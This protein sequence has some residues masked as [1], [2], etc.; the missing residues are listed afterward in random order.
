MKV[1]AKRPRKKLPAVPTLGGSEMLQ[2]WRRSKQP[3]V[4]RVND[5]L[6]L[7]V[8]DDRS[9]HL[10]AQLVERLETIA[11]IRDG[12]KDVDEGRTVSLEDFQAKARTKH[13]IPH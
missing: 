13:G 9:V 3:I 2:N 4:L 7:S 1:V 12:L 5:E 6:I 10:L 11:A 8:D